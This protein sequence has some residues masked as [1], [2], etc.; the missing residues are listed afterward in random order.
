[1]L[2]ADLVLEPRNRETGAGALEAA[3]LDVDASTLGLGL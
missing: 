2:S 1:M 3:G